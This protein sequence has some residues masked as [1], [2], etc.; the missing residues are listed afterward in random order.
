MYVDMD[1]ISDVA[2]TIPRIHGRIY[3][4]FPPRSVS[5]DT[6][7]RKSEKSKKF[8][9]FR[10]KVTT[11]PLAHAGENPL[12]TKNPSFRHRDNAT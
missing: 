4:R 1:I 2:E 11:N 3:V 10:L 9:R 6:K 7:S 12:F 5:F 8:H